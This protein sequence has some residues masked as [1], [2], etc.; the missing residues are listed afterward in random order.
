MSVPSKINQVDIS[1]SFSDDQIEIIKSMIARNLSDAELKLFLYECVR[2]GLDPIA[3]QIYAIKRGGQLCIQT[4]IDGFRLIAERTGMYAPGRDTEFTYDS[5]GHLVC[6]KVFVKKKTSDGTWHEVSATAYL[7]EYNSNQGLWKRLPHVM[8]EKCA[9]ARVIRRCFPS[10]LSGIYSDDEMHQAD[11][12][13][14]NPNAN[15][16]VEACISQE[17]WESIN[18]FLEGNNDLINKLKGFC[19]VSDL[20]NIKESQVNAVKNYIVNYLN[21]KKGEE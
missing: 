14:C 15:L 20:C 3:K 11:V 10:D 4:G 19:G 12:Q 8:L 6:A 18:K 9:E 1:S 13:S 2:T 17:K 5:N 21:R 16:Q 7:K